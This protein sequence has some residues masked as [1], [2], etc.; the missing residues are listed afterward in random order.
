M[1]Y[2]SVTYVTVYVYQFF[3]DLY[4]RDF[5]PRK[6]PKEQLDRKRIRQMFPKSRFRSKSTAW[7]K[8]DFKQWNFLEGHWQSE[9]ISAKEKFT[10]S[11]E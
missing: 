9:K 1:I 10:K 2:Y 8:W 5:E 6:F 7:K 11:L 4:Q 3:L